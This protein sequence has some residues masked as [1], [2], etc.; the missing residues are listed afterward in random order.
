MPQVVPTDQLLRQVWADSD[1]ADPA[2][3]WVTVRRL[4][5]KIELDPDE[6]RHLLTD[7]SGG[8]RLVASEPGPD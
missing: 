6:P 7:P 3:V 8:Y 2:Y 1:A 5:R 4:R